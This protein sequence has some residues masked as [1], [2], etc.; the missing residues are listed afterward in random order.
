VAAEVIGEKLDDRAAA[1]LWP[2][3]HIGV[4]ATLELARP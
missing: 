2:S 4:V 1:G 3:D